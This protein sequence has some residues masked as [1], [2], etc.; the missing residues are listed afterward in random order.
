MSSVPSNKSLGYYH[1]SGYGIHR[2]FFLWLGKLLFASIVL[3]PQRELSCRLP[4]TT[5]IEVLTRHIFLGG[6]ANVEPLSTVWSFGVQE[7]HSSEKNRPI[8]LLPT[9]DRIPPYLGLT[10]AL[11]LIDS[12]R[13][14]R[15]FLNQGIDMSPEGSITK[16]IR[17][18]RIG[19]SLAAE[20]LWRRYFPQLVQIA[21]E[22]LQ[23][24]PRQKA[25]EEDVALSA[26]NC[27]YRAV[28]EGRYP[29]LADRND[30]WRLL[31]QITSHRAINLRRSENRQRRGGGRVRYEATCNLSDSASYWS[32]AEPASDDTPIP[33]FAAIMADEC[34]GLL[35]QLHDADLRKIAVAKMEGY[36]NA[37]IAA[38]MNCSERTIERRLKLIRDKW[39]QEWMQAKH[40]LR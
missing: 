36:N 1:I 30:L 20:A 19:N 23:G 15:P 26:M 28:Q 17:E 16:W 11:V 13:E 4:K 38:Q 5:T 6:N 14:D 29:D 27:F 8:N 2:K 31:L 33:E 18:I 10:V 22:K 21:R 24:A 12:R 7:F 3:T 39:K 40:G 37:E 9:N 34:R 32:L 35:E 25:D